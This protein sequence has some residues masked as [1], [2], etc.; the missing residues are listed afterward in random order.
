VLLGFWIS[1]VAQNKYTKLSNLKNLFIAI[2][3][4]LTFIIA[5]P[6][7]SVVAYYEFENEQLKNKS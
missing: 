1:I 6:F 2:S 7:A 4:Y 5:W 3:I